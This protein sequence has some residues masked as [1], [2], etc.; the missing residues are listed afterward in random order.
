MSD[1]DDL[2]RVLVEDVDEE[3]LS[4]MPNWFKVL[5]EAYEKQK[6]MNVDGHAVKQDKE[7]S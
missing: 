7:R 3:I 5:R 2:A 1:E 4:E 6:I